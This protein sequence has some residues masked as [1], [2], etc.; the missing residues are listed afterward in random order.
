MT[1]AL[2]RL[3]ALTQALQESRSVIE[4][5]QIRDRAEALR[6]YARQSGENLGLQND[7]A[8]I[9]LRAE[10]WAGELLAEIERGNGGRPGKNSYHDGTS[11]ESTIADAG[12]AKM[13]AYRW[14]SIAA[15]LIGSFEQFIAETRAGE[16]D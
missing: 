4:V 2:V 13:T 10:R 11:F 15:L 12:I 14:Q 9:K 8:E 7:F 3:D 16:K 6:Q 5:K 1:T